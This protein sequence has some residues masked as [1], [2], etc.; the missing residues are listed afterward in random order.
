[1]SAESTPTDGVWVSY[2]SDGSGVYVHASEIAAY[3]E[4]AGYTRD[5]IFVPWNQSVNDA[6]RA[7]REARHQTSSTA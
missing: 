2:Y 6:E 4:S 1:M 3:R 7:A 5:V